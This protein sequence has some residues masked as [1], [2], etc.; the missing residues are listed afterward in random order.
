MLER[1][2]RNRVH[3]AWFV[4][5]ATFVTLITTA[6]FRATPGVLIVPLEDEFGW[7]PATI[8]IA[9]SLGLLTFGLGAPFSAALMERFGVRRVMVV[10]LVVIALGASAT[11]LISAP[12]QLYLLWGVVVGSATGAVSVPLAATVANR[13]FEKQ[14]GL[15]T[16]ILT[17]SNASGQL[18]F[19]PSLAWLATH[20]GWRAASLAVSAV[21]VAVVLPIVAIVVRDRPQTIGLQ[22][23]GATEDAEAPPRSARPFRPAIDGLRLGMRNRNFWLLAASFFVC[24]ASTNGLIGTHLI[25]AAHDHGMSAVA[26]ASLL[27]L[28]GV[29]DMVGTIA[30]GW[31]TDRFDP[32]ALLFWYY[33]LRGLSLL[34][35]PYAFASPRAGLIAFVVF[36]GLDW[37]ATVPPT[38][39]LTADTFGRERVGIVFGWIFASHQ[40][41]AAF[42]AWAAG[43][44]RDW[45]GDYRTAFLVAGGICLVASALVLRI[46]LPSAPRRRRRAP[47][48][49]E[50]AA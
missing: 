39:A 40:F 35:L 46:S 20:Y 25:A 41:G 14:R 26:G 42:A 27:A 4:V 37:V 16:G 33:G 8:S 49:A 30:S 47:L 45:T 15:V 7:S 32:R 24:G 28:I 5:V 43:A 23:Y 3:Y 11:T 29:F 12:W 22:P 31:L 19:L 18:V 13:W 48:P 1:L 21:A 2:A 6:G 34:A 38:V 10:A 36:Y 50:A 44:T 17:A 9:V